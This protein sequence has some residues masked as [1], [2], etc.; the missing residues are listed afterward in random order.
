[1]QNAFPVLARNSRGAKDAP[2]EFGHKVLNWRR[3]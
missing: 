3:L 1:M 2:A